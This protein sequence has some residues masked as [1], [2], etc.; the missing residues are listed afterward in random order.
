MAPEKVRSRLHCIHNCRLTDTTAHAATP[1]RTNLDASFVL[2]ILPNQHDKAHRTKG[3]D[4]NA[5][6]SNLEA[7]Y[8]RGIIHP[9]NTRKL[10]EARVDMSDEKTN[11]KASYNTTHQHDKTHRSK[12]RHEC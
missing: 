10:T 3:V 4:M 6:R 5:E 9:T 7:S 2:Y 8:F 12:G 11:Q 1:T